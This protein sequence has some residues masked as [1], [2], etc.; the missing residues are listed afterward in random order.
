MTNAKTF[1]AV[2]CFA[3]VGFS[4]LS[5]A[6]S[7]PDQSAF[8]NEVTKALQ[9]NGFNPANLKVGTSIDS[10]TS[11]VINDAFDKAL[12]GGRTKPVAK[13]IEFMNGL[14]QYSCVAVV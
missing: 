14:M 12:L 2:I 8:A 1:S 4:L 3:I 11:Q 10:V 6:E 9:Q 5:K 13:N 7:K